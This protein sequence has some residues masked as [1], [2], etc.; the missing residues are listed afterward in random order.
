MTP[1]ENRLYRHKVTLREVCEEFGIE[2]E[3]AVYNLETCSHCS[4]W[5]KP[6]ELIPDLD[7]NPIC[8]IC[9]RFYGL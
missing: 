5:F 1:F 2:I 7:G 3:D 9:N 4:I 8:R 6:Q